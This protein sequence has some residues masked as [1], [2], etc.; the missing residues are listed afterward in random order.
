MLLVLGPPVDYLSFVCPK[1]PLLYLL[2]YLADVQAPRV[3]KAPF[4]LVI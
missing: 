2:L 4:L 1:M 3:T